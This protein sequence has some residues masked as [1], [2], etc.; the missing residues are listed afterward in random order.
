MSSTIKMDM[1]LECSLCRDVFREPKTLGCLHS[2]CLECLE[3]YI[4]RNHSNV[5][6]TCPICRTPFPSQSQ[7]Q[8]LN[9]Q[10]DTFLLNSLNIHNSLINSISPQK[11]KKQKLMCLDGE[12]EAPFYCLDCQEYLCEVCSKSHKIMKLSKNHQLIPI[13]KMKNE[14]QNNSVTKSN[15]QNYCQTHQQKEMEL[16]C[17]DCNLPICLLCISQHPSHKILVISDIIENEK[18]SLLDVINQ[19]R[20]LFLSFILSIS[21]KEF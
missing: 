17:D 12:N 5:N 4:S 7:E 14:D 11:M 19:V 1:E 21:I 20:F 15:L 3:I 10:T 2:F 9:L 13:D 16:F 6:L 18:Q 8:L